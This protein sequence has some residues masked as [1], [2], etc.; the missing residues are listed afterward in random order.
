[1]N[2]LPKSPTLFQTT[3]IKSNEESER[4]RKTLFSASVSTKKKAKGTTD[5]EFEKARRQ[6]QDEYMAR[7]DKQ[8]IQR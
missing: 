5:E 7:L 1:M 2:P 6:A 8:F 4:V 3:S